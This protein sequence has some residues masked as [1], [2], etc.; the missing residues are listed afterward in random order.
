MA[1]LTVGQ[2]MDGHGKWIADR[3]CGLCGLNKVWEVRFGDHRTDVFYACQRCD[4]TEG[5]A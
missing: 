1:Y 3:K 2:A 5:K 4:R